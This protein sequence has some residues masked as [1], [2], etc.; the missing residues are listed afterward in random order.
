MNAMAAAIRVNQSL[1]VLDLSNSY[2]GDGGVALAQALRGNQSLKVIHLNGLK[3]S[4]MPSKKSLVGVL[5]SETTNVVYYALNDLGINEEL[6]RDLVAA[7][8]HNTRIEELRI[9]PTTT[10]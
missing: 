6:G 3:E 5:S 4:T 2:M 1:E 8:K 10:F 7:L 9:H